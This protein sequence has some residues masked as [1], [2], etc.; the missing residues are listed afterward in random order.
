VKSQIR[1]IGSRRKIIVVFLM[2]ILLPSL[3]VGYLSLNTVLKR[4]DAV[5]RLLE[6]NLWVSGEAALQNCERT[7]LEYEAGT[8]T[9]E[10][11]SPLYP[12][13]PDSPIVI[14]STHTTGE[15]TLFL[16]DSEFRIVYPVTARSLQR[17]SQGD[18][19]EAALQTFREIENLEFSRQ[20]YMGAVAL[21]EEYLS[22]ASALHKP[23]AMQGLARCLVA[24]G[25]Y[26]RA[27]A[28]YA[29]LAGRYSQRH[30]RAGHPYGIAAGLQLAE[31]ERRQNRKE[32]SI[33]RLLTLYENVR[34]GT[35]ILN[36]ATYDF[37]VSELESSLDAHLNTESYPD[38][39]KTYQ[40]QKDKPSPYKARLTFIDFIEKSAVPSIRERT[41][42][43]KSAGGSA[44]GRFPAV[45]GDA[46]GFVSF[47]TLPD[48]HD[49]RTFYGGFLWNLEILPERFLQPVLETLT[50]ESELEFTLV[51]GNESAEDDR[52]RLLSFRSM[53]LPWKLAV[54]QP[55]IS[56]VESSARW[57]M[58]LYGSLLIVIVA[59][60][61]FGTFLIMRDMARE[62]EATRLK[63]E[64]VHNISHELKTP[65]TLIRLYGETLQR[66]KNL[67]AKE[68]NESYEIITKESE[69]LSHMVN[70]V[71]DFSR[72]EMGSKEFHMKQ[73]DLARVIRETL[74]SYR[75]H[76]EKK[77]FI[78]HSEIAS[79]LPDMT[80][81]EEAMVSVLVNLLGN[82]MK[83]SPGE[84]EVRVRLVRIGNNAV[85]QVTD[86]G[87][88]IAPSEH[89]KIFQRFYR[90]G[91]SMVSGTSGSGLGLPL[92]K[93]IVEA[94]GGHIDVESDVGKGSRFSIAIPFSGPKED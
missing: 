56:T 10:N 85:L 24:A 21:Y 94:H 13:Q 46:Y 47:A 91:D 49:G 84:K 39:H 90:S 57:E 58:V 70:N 52:T 18:A 59:L 40:E 26:S 53:P 88:G 25:Y 38:L 4:R 64:F 14:D 31:L 61:V 30:N 36:P 42:V 35:W 28:V 48:F 80:F 55:G 50:R 23:F 16:L 44:T 41:A 17:E 32:E 22:S 82:A 87:V 54:S 76:L 68:K 74:D 12:S 72:I 43:F 33:H 67:S 66:K 81:D 79:D 20:D 6:S 51:S 8:L 78:V 71:L 65:L 62:S 63:T 89:E 9:K 37:F 60:M 92:V 83:F 29:D 93:H 34:T 45:R 11:F 77:R 75:Y 27:M 1:Q 5:R 2:A 3:I 15:H 19:H 73:E 69:R 7:L 86:K